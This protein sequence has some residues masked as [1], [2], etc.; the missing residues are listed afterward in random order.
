MA[1]SSGLLLITAAAVSGYLAD[2]FGL[3]SVFYAMTACFAM[4]SILS[5]ILLA[6]AGKSGRK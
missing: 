3:E 1:K 5:L 6:R 4:A 2:R